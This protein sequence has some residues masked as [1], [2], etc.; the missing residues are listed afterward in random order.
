LND[1]L[2]VLEELF[3]CFTGGAGLEQVLDGACDEVL[4]VLV[5]DGVAV[6]GVGIGGVDGFFVGFVGGEG[7]GEEA[8][9]LGAPGVGFFLVYWGRLP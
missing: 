6:G 1:G 9:H 3:G 2:E 4:G 5:A 8:E 7:S